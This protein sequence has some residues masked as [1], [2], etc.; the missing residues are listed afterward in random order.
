MHSVVSSGAEQNATRVYLIFDFTEVVVERLA[1]F[2]TLHVSHKD[3]FI[4]LD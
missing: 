3:V 4:V 2:D 1:V